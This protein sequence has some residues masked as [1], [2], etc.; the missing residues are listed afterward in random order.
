MLSDGQEIF[1]HL[2]TAPFLRPCSREELGSLF[3][4]RGR[5]RPTIAKCLPVASSEARDFVHQ[6]GEFLIRH[7][8]VV[9]RIRHKRISSK[10]VPLTQEQR[11]SGYRYLPTIEIGGGVDGTHKVCFPRSVLFGRRSDRQSAQEL[12]LMPWLNG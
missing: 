3:A 5:V 2:S 4:A 9:G 1:Q 12:D 10:A 6:R 11:L 8:Q 7:L